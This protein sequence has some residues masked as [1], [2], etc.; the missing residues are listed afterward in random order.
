MH[1]KAAQMFLD[2]AAKRGIFKPISDKKSS[3]MYKSTV[4]SLNTS[5][6]N[7]QYRDY[8]NKSTYLDLNS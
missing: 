2:E 6:N 1:P 5:L 3:I 7:T 8:L 4:Q